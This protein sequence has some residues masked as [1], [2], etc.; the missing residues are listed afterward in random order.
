MSHVFDEMF[1][2][3]T[4]AQEILDTYKEGQSVIVT[5]AK[6]DNSIVSYAGTMDKDASRSHS[7]AIYTDEGWKRFNI[8]RVFLI[9][10]F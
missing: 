9:H 6:K 4:K 1:L 8:D 3:E 2:S 10:I 7:V 5:F